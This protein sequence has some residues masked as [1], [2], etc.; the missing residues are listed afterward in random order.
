G[1]TA[2][3]TLEIHAGPIG[4]PARLL[5]GAGRAEHD[6][7]ISE[8]GIYVTRW[9]KKLREKI[10]RRSARLPERRFTPQVGLGCERFL[11]IGCFLRKRRLRSKEQRYQREFHEH[12]SRTMA[13]FS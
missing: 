8:I 1:P 11:K 2:R 12:S 13:A 7:I 10:V 4:D 3:A 6:W 9:R 5:C